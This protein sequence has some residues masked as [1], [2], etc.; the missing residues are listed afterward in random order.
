MTQAQIQHIFQQ[1]YNHNTWK[2]FLGEAFLNARLL[3]KPEELSGINKDVALEASKLGYILLDEEGIER[4]VAI[5][6]VVLAKGIVL[7]RNRVGL[8][9]LLR[10]YWKNIDA[11]FI[12]YFNP[13]NTNWRFTYV[14]ELTGFDSEG[15]LISIKTE[16]KRY[17]YILG[18]GETCRTAAERFTILITKG[19]SVTLDDIKDAFSVEKLSKAFFDGYKNHYDIFCDYMVS[20]PNIRQA[21]FDGDEKKI[22]D[23]NKKLLGRIVFLYF[24][25]KKGWL[26]VPKQSRWGEGRKDF[27]SYVFETC[28]NKEMFYSEILVKLFFDTLNTKRKDDIIEL[29]KGEQCRIPYLNGGLFEEENSKYRSM[30]FPGQLFSNLFTFF[31]Q[32]NFTIYEDDPNDH[33]IAV[34]PEMLGHIFENLLE[35]NK[36]KGAYYT[37][38]EIVHYMCQESLIEFLT[39]WFEQHGYQITGYVGFNKPDQF[40]MFSVNEGR[41]GQM[42]LEY[43]NKSQSKVISRTLIERLLKKNLTETDKIEVIKHHNEFQ[44]ALDSV[45]ICDPA[46]GSGAFPM[47]LLHEVF[48]AKLILYSFK[49]GHV[50]GFNAASV[51]L[52]IIQNSIYGVD[53]EKGAVDIARLRFWLSLIV[54]EPE[55]RPLPNLDYKIVVGNSLLNKLKIGDF[56]E[57]VEIDWNI[58]PTSDNTTELKKIVRKSLDK[59]I[60]EQIKFFSYEGDKH[61]LQS[62]IRNLMIDLLLKQLELTKHKFK[63]SNTIQGTFF[64]L[65]AKDKVKKVELDNKIAGYEKAINK[66]VKLKT[67]PEIPLQYFDWKLNFPEIMNEQIAS[68]TGF[69]III[70]NPP[71]LKERDNAHIFEPVNN[72]KIGKLYHQGK[73]DYWYY[74]LHTAIDISNPSATISFITSRYWI[75]SQGAKKLILRVKDQLS[76]LTVVDIGKLKVFDNVAGQHMIGIYT[77][78]RR[79]TFKYKKVVDDIKAIENEFDSEILRIHLL[80]NNDVFRGNEIIFASQEIT[81]DF[82]KTVGSFYELGQGV[83][84]APDKVSRKQLKKLKN[85]EYNVG[86]GVYVL[87]EKECKLVN[88]NSATESVLVKY[89]DPN[90]VKKWKINPITKKWLIYS[91][92]LNKK[93]IA[94]DRSLAHIKEHLDYYSP[95]I[96]SS[97][98]PYGIHRPREKKF[99][100]NKKILFKIM[101]DKN[102]FTIDVEK[103]YVGMSFISIIEKSKDY[104]LEFLLGILNSKYA[105]H[106]FYTYGKK[107]GAGV[108]I[109]VEKLRTFPLP[110]KR[111]KKLEQIVGQLLLNENVIPTLEQQIDYIVYKL[112]DLTFKEI[113]TID[114]SIVLTEEEYKSITI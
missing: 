86:D 48:N 110:N 112:Y 63:E 27:I 8:R 30:L 107:R 16:P 89:L 23:F 59:L 95:L 34:D 49:W 2:Q 47:G 37:P 70:A 103:Y 52:E 25:Q 94:S 64:T 57:I 73:M 51:K 97:N 104:T 80:S 75:N 45:K 102:E 67:T 87:N 14:S 24:I 53:I 62:R 20:K 5:Y 99:F 61:E 13:E 111:S 10:K 21:I 81:N 60:A 83:V 56:E 32:Y 109:G 46:I 38:K 74:F 114:P 65:T 7:E 9:N 35:D 19:K 77:K 28:R 106:W 88:T 26:G 44:Q 4:Q 36:D 101:F 76:F 15:E 68:S 1:R 17:T 18:E 40:Q 84:E 78:K 3:S 113:K 98:R 69:D 91:D 90:D 29:I 54:D 105:H 42:L 82:T 12:A 31:N 58:K 39:T 6:E 108:D 22:R 72:S 33:T 85:Q 55:P 11:A 96:T 43:E 71:Y 92:S 93:K 41:K 66:L 79:D 100:E 50:E